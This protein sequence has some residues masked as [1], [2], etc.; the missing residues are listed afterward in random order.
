MPLALHNFISCYWYEEE[1]TRWR[2]SNSWLGITN[3]RAVRFVE[4]RQLVLLEHSLRE[5][6]MQWLCRIFPIHGTHSLYSH[7]F[8]CFHIILSFS[9]MHC[10]PSLLPSVRV[11]VSFPPGSFPLCF[12]VLEKMEVVSCGGIHL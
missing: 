7:P 9:A 10:F 8:C 6:K 3:V 12:S 5:M 11:V 4:G 2:A 1:G